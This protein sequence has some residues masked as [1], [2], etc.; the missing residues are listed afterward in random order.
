MSKKI[1]TSAEFIM[2]RERKK[3]MMPRHMITAAVVSGVIP[4]SHVH[5]EELKL[6]ERVKPSETQ[7]VKVS[8]RGRG[9]PPKSQS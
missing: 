7:K 8:G 2:E 3:R 1:M 4:M 6:P 5:K 9:R